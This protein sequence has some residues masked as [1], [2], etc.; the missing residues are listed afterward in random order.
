MIGPDSINS[1]I[2]I[3]S[4]MTRL[5]THSDVITDWKKY[6]KFDVASLWLS[7]SK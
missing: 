5:K 7:F 1:L 6:I 3:K 4:E 2:I